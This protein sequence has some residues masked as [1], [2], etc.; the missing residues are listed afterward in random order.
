M[1]C[2]RS[3][4]ATASARSSDSIVVAPHLADHVCAACLQ[5]GYR[6]SVRDRVLAEGCQAMVAE[7]G[8][9]IL[10]GWSPMTDNWGDAGRSACSSSPSN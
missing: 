8:G 7:T 3:V 5:L 10:V 2:E 6:P 4:L 9:V 1:S